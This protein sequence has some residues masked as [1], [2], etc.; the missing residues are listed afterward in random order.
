M[1]AAVLL[2]RRAI[3]LRSVAIAAIIVLLHRPETLLSPGFQMSFAATTALVAAFNGLQGATWLR[4]WPTWAK[5]IW[6]LVVS[7]VIAGGAT[8][9]FAA[10]HFNRLAVYGLPANLL[11]VPVMGSIVIPFA[12]VALLLT[13]FGLS[14]VAYWIMDLALQWILGVAARVA[15]LPGA[16]ELVQS[17][18]TLAFALIATGGLALC[19]WQGHARWV[20]I[21]PILVGLGLWQIPDRPSLLISESG[22]LVGVMTPEGRALSRERG[23]GF[24]AG[25]WLEDDGDSADQQ[26][27]AA[28]PG[29]TQP[30]PALEA[31]VVTAIGQF[32]LWHGT[33]QSAARAAAD[34]CA[35]Y[36]IVVLNTDP[37]MDDVAD[38][39]RPR[40]QAPLRTME[41]AEPCLLLSPRVLGASGAVSLRHDADGLH[42]DTSRAHQGR[43]LWSPD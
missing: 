2:D 42:I 8:A 11:T 28:R 30:D 15:D 1:F 41:A 35:R 38:I 25:I 17:P 33:G 6:A 3:T 40:L 14:W 27:A 26:E 7:S 24:V 21:A 16:V 29:W 37:E 20:A 18:S 12:V 43:R 36:D 10:A 34:A 13:P 19:L 9:P 5:W 4:A 22:G 39:A 23:D 32:S 31:G